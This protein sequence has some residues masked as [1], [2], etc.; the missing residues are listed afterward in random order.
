[1]EEN[2]LHLFLQCVFSIEVWRKSF[3]RLI[4]P[5]LGEIFSS[6]DIETIQKRFLNNHLLKQVWKSL[7]K[8][9]LWKIWLMRNSIIFKAKTINLNMVVGS[10]QAIMHEVIKIKVHV[11]QNIFDLYTKE[12]LWIK[13]QSSKDEQR[14]EVSVKYYE[15]EN[16]LLR[17][18][19]PKMYVC[20]VNQNYHLELFYGATKNNPG[21]EGT[22][23][24][25]F[26]LGRKRKHHYNWGLGKTSNNQ[27]ECLLLG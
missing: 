17:I 5:R 20:M 11:K 12:R 15:K 14:Q 22:G 7:P 26:D 18:K 9:I 1:M 10:S 25:F 16:W 6:P 2:A 4:S 21:M 8:F 23:G 19:Q 24:V 27:A 3:A 13:H